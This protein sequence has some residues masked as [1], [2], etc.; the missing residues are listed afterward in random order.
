M[1]TQAWAWLAAGVVALGLNGFY[2]DGGFEC[3]HRAADRIESRSSAVLALATGRAQQFLEQARV[4]TLPDETDAPVLE[5]AVARAQTTIARTET[6]FDRW[7][8]VSDRQEVR[9]VRL[10]ATRARLQ[11]VQAR[12]ACSRIPAVTVNPVAFKAVRI[13]TCPRIRVSVQRIPTIDVPTVS[14]PKIDIP[15]VSIPK[16]SVP[17]IHVELQGAGPV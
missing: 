17:A 4:A 1:K 2:H 3:L 13:E 8:A 15:R 14:I 7:Q 5:A 16:I 6:T 12:L 11:T 10:E 9:F